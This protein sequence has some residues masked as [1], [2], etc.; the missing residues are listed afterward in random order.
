MLVRIRWKKRSQSDRRRLRNLALAL[1]SLLTPSALIAFTIAFWRISA[2]LRWTGDFFIST[3]IFSHWQVW[4]I[5]AAVLL[6]IAR[7]LG[8]YALRED[9]L[10]GL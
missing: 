4:L 8:R 5:A 7:V 2:D 9:D 1:A 10:M 3:G 6:L